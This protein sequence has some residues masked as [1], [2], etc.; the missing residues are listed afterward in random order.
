MKKFVL[1]LSLIL[2]IMSCKSDQEDKKTSKLASQNTEI[3]FNKDKW[4]LKEGKDYVYREQMYEAVLYNDT[5]RSLNEVELIALL[6]DPDYNE[7]GHLYYRISETRMMNWKVKT[8]TMVVKLVQ[9]GSIE[10]IKVHE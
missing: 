8:K 4:V 2:V 1:L 9:D 6:G 3:P 5:I 10:W 7:E